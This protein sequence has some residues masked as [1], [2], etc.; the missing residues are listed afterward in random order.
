MG[1]TNI[2]KREVLK[3]ILRVYFPCTTTYNILTTTFTHFIS[4]SEEASRKA[5]ISQ[6]NKNIHFEYKI[7]LIIGN[8]KK[9]VKK[10][11][12]LSMQQGN[13]MQIDFTRSYLQYEYFL[14]RTLVFGHLPISWAK[15]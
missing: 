13:S 14:L 8:Y 3:K 12:M 4:K 7:L 10:P 2:S 11:E 9:G 1:E 15:N 6:E 5:E